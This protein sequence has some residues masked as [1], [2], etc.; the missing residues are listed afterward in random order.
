MKTSL[1]S[2]LLLCAVFVSCSSSDPTGP[3]IKKTGSPVTSY[4]KLQ[5]KGKYLTGSKTGGK[6]IQLKGVSLFWSNTNWFGDK[7]F[8]DYT[9]NALVD[10]WKAE[11]V[12]VPMG[13][14]VPGGADYN[15]SYL[16]DKTENMERVRAA[17]DAAIAKG[18]YVIIDWHSHR[19]HQNPEDAKIFFEEM[20]RDY[21]SYDHVIFEIFNEPINEFWP[22]LKAYAEEIIP[23]I[24]NHSS[25]LIL[26]GTR[27]YSRHVQEVV[28]DALSDNNVAYVLHFYAHNHYLNRYVQNT[29]DPSFKEAVEQALDAGLHIFISEY[30][31]V[32][33]NGG[34]GEHLNSHHAEHMDEWLAFMDEN[35]ISSCSWSVNN[36]NE[37]ASTFK[38]T[39]IPGPD[40]NYADPENMTASGLYIFNMLNEWAK[41]APWR[42]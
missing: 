23:V 19:A 35:K 15:G 8:N 29:T 33:S 34:Q 4:G 25:N 31:T 1:F 37:G 26:M 39:F 21:G 9:V 10:D 14:D 42:E 30:G 18:V 41:K 16:A 5:V 38:P 6:P 12:R 13:Y 22:E 17:V 7:F 2:V 28:G 20:A 40:A 3:A 27:F 11:V 32:N 24:R 36:K